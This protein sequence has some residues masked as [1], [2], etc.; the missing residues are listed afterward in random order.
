MYLSC[1]EYHTKIIWFN[2]SS[3]EMD[4]WSH[5][6]VRWGNLRPQILERSRI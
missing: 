3:C 6:D 4:E 1:W 5:N 2:S